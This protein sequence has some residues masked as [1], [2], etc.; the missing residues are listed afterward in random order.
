M[1]IISL[2]VL[3]ACG[4]KTDTD[5]DTPTDGPTWYQDVQPIIA[6]NC[7]QCHNSEAPLGGAFAGLD[8]YE[9]VSVLAEQLISKMSNEGDDADPYF[10]P[11]VNARDTEECET[12]LPFTGVYT[13]SDEEY[14]T[15]AEWMETGKAEGDPDDPAPYTIPESL[16]IDGDLT[17]LSARAAFDVPVSDDT[18]DTFRCFALEDDDGNIGMSEEAWVTGFEFTPG[19]PTVVHH[20]LVYTVDDIDTELANGLAEDEDNNSWEC[21]GGLSR[22]DGSHDITNYNLIYGWVPGSLPLELLDGAAIRVPQATG[23]VMQIHYNIIAVGPDE[24]ASDQSSLLAQTT[25]ETPTHEALMNLFG[26]ASQGQSENVEDGEFYVPAGESG[27]V[28]TY[29]ETFGTGLDNVDIRIWGM[30]PH[31]HLAGTDIKMTL[32]KSTGDEECLVHVPK[33]DYNWQQMHTYD[34][35]FDDL[36]R[37]EG[38]DT[39]R[40]RCTMDNTDDNAFLRE[41]LGGAVEEGIILGE[42]TQDEMCIVAVGLICDGLCPSGL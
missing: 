34:G 14:E 8:D 19:N 10:M 40:V 37:V 28:E 3:A 1:R 12:V 18:P 25:T 36:P 11:P 42:R 5:T 17:A 16:H 33:W 2:L 29:S 20:V 15:F 27:W 26:V 31:M 21:S 9:I 6:E 39:L 7:L 35:T 4:G 38:G 32:D 41:Y 22:A 13:V 30:T 24:T 23:L